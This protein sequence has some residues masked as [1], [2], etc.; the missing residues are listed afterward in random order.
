[1]AINSPS[2]LTSFAGYH[3]Y[4][5]APKLLLESEGS[6]VY[7]KLAPSIS[8]IGGGPVSCAELATLPWSTFISISDNCTPTPYLVVSY[9]DST[10]QNCNGRDIQT[11]RSWK[12]TDRAGNSG[13]LNQ[14]ISTE[15]VS[16]KSVVFPAN[17]DWYC[18]SSKSLDPS[19]TGWPM[20]NG[21]SINHYCGITIDYKDYTTKICG[22]SSNIRRH[23][24]ITDCCT[25]YAIN[26]D[27]DIYVHDTTKPIITCP[28]PFRFPTNVKECYSHQFI[29][30]I[31]AMDECNPLD[32]SISVKVDGGKSYGVGQKVILGLGFHTF[33]YTV[34]DACGNASKC[35]TTAEVYDGQPPLLICNPIDVVLTT[36]ST[37]VC[38]KQFVSEYW[39]DCSGLSN[40]TLKIR[41]LEDNCGDPFD[42][43]VFKDCVTICCSGSN[44]LV[45]VE[46]QATDK[47]G[48]SITCITEVNIKS[49]QPIQIQCQDT[50][51]LSCGIPIP[52][53]PTSVNFCG[54]YTVIFK[55]IF[56]DRNA[57]GIG[58]IIRRYIV[59]TFDGRKDSCQTVIIIGLGTSAFGP[60]D[61]TCPA[62]EVNLIGCTIP[63]LNSIPGIGLKDTAK[64]CALV[65]VSLQIDTFTDLGTPCLRVRRTWTIKDALQPLINVICV[66]NINIIDTVRP[67]LSGVRDTTVYAGVSCSAIVD[68]PPLIATDCDPN[69]IITNSLNGQGADIGPLSFPKGMTMIKYRAVDKCGNKDSLTIKI[70]VL[71]TVG[72]HI[73][74]QSDSIVNCGVNFVPGA[75]TIIAS[76]TQVAT[77]VLKSDTIRNKCSI[78]KINFKRIV[79]DTA[80]RTDSCTFMVTF[81]AADTLFCDQISWPKDTILTNCNKSINPDSLNLKPIYTYI[82]GACSRAI[83]TYRDSVVASNG[84]SG[85]TNVTKRIWTVSDTCSIPANVCSYI[86]TISVID[87]SAPLLKVPMDTCVYLKYKN[88]CDTLLSF[89][90]SATAMDCD[91]AVSIKNVIIGST[92]TAGASLIRRYPLGIS[93]VLVIAKDACG[94][95]AKDTVIIQVKDTVKPVAAC[96]K[97]NNYLNDQSKVTILAKQFD[98]GST[99]NCTAPAQLR[100]SWTKNVNDTLLEVNCNVLK[101]LRASG[102]TIIDSVRVFPFER[103]FILW[104]TDA[105]GNQDT[106]KGNR[107]LAFFDTLNL[108]GKAAIRTAAIQGQVTMINGKNIPNVILSAIG[109]E[110]VQN[111]T[112]YKGNFILKNLKPGIYKIFP[113]KNDD[114]TL[115]VSTSDLIAIQKHILGI[116]PLES[117]DQFVAADVNNDGDISSIDLIELR[118]LILGIYDQFPENTSW[119]FFDQSLMARTDDHFAL[120][121]FQNPF[122]EAIEAKVIEQDFTGVKIGDVNGSASPNL[123]LLESR[124][125]NELKLKLPDIWSDYNQLMELPVRVNTDGLEGLQ[126]ILQF[127]DVEILGLKETSS[128]LV[129]RNF[130]NESLFAKGIV[131]FSWN[132][133]NQTSL[134]GEQLLFTLYIKPRFK[135]L[136]S[137]H[138]NIISTTF[139]SEGY[140]SNQEIINLSLNFEK[141]ITQAKELD[142][143]ILLQNAPNPFSQSTLVKFTLPTSGRVNWTVTDMTGKLVDRWSKEMAVGNHQYK[144]DKNILGAPGIYYYRIEFNGYN[145]VKKLILID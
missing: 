38:A 139:K 53:T 116:T 128:S 50:I 130:I 94:N 127:S 88:L 73:L 74:C 117:M 18:P 121:D 14:L 26:Y 29:P 6:C 44:N 12:V 142:K 105:S 13:Y 100:F 40:V 34:T 95:T 11:I 75:A 17:V 85:C 101:L 97:S 113:Y 4:S 109:E 22:T 90:G 19:E 107:F 24:S 55:T 67:I 69:V 47:N 112:D 110:Q 82:Q 83:T 61:V 131:R 51:R 123:L 119:K 126:G 62:S 120:K 32:L 45:L 98:G 137:D 10:N 23:W 144:V 56:D 103:N 78:T 65:T 135:G 43:L 91:P 63:D 125:R 96:K 71:D 99:D 37:Q 70:T 81:R 35:T 58:T 115:G 111:K 33:E 124:S 143:L 57:A 46:I 36:D 118:K 28:A 72:F 48:N 27:Q 79:T 2:L 84:P 20:Y 59:T 49:K 39:D 66:Q 136:I 134:S 42:D 30:A 64:P 133:L 89:L 114:P 132:T 31:L 5:V 76:C 102:D 92:D 104:V 138:I 52:S 15:R 7:D 141:N 60:D 9:K 108:C 106:C 86:Q 122:V 68:L 93:L 8:P 87:N 140:T 54:D 3:Y 21:K 129:S 16:I 41:K 80:G 1:M 145:E 77:N 25:L